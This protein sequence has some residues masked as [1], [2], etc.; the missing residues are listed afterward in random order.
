[1]MVLNIKDRTVL[2]VDGDLIINKPF[3]CPDKHW[4]LNQETKEFE[5]VLH[6]RYA[7]YQ[8]REPRT[9]AFI[10]ESLQLVNDI[11][12]ALIRWRSRGRPGLS[13]ITRRLLDH[14][15]NPKREHQ[16]F[17][18]QLEAVET[19]IFLTEDATGRSIAQRIEGDGGPLERWC[20]KMA[21]GTGKTVLM[22]MLIAWQ[23]LNYAGASERQRRERGWVRNFLILAPNLTVRDRLQVLLPS[24]NGNYYDQFALVPPGGGLRQKLNRAKLL[25]TNWHKLAP[26]TESGR[27]V[28]KLD[29]ETDVAFTA[30]VFDRTLDLTEPFLVFNDEAHHAWR[31]PPDAKPTEYKK[32]DRETATV[33]IQGLDRLHKMGTLVR[34]YDFTATPFPPSGKKTQRGERLFPWVVSDFGLSDAIESGLVKTP[35]IAAEDNLTSP[36]D[37]PLPGLEE[38]GLER[39]SKLF[40]LYEEEG[41]KE[42]LRG[43]KNMIGEHLP[44]LVVSAYQLLAKS[45]SDTLKEWRRQSSSVPPVMV[46]ICNRTETAERV[47][48]LF[49][50]LKQVHDEMSETETTLHYDSTTIKAVEKI[51]AGERVVGKAGEQAERLREIA[52][53]VGVEG[54]P[55]GQIRH[56][57]AVNMISEGWDAKTVTHIMGLRAFTSQLLCEQVIGRGLRRT[58]Y[59]LNEDGSFEP[60][61]VRIFG[62]PFTLL[63]A[64]KETTSRAIISHPPVD[65]H[66]VEKNRKF[67]VA[68]PAL[69]RVE[70]APRRTLKID[71]DDVDPLMLRADEVFTEAGMAKTLEYVTA[72]PDETVLRDKLEAIRLQTLA[73]DAARVFYRSQEGWPDGGA[74]MWGQL[75]LVMLDFVKNP[76]KLQIVGNGVSERVVIKAGLGQIVRHLRPYL[77]Q[78]EY[79]IMEGVYENPH[80]PLLSTGEMRP[81]VTRRHPEKIDAFVGRTHL[82]VGVYD[83]ILEKQAGRIF[84]EHRNVA[85]WVKNDREHIGFKVDYVFEG[86]S[87]RYYPDFVVRL[88]PTG[89]ESGRREDENNLIVETKGA[90]EAEACAKQQYLNLWLKA[91]NK[92]GRWGKWENFGLVFEQDFPRLIARLDAGA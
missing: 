79:Q 39:R 53:T 30:R 37:D 81:W 43:G 23:T 82:N 31:V 52:K 29:P 49:I 14:W 35:R 9:G 85:G 15:E 83:S 61:Y 5:L 51:E 7:S 56:V 12:E 8:L 70:T 11:R 4:K 59:E 62:V 65:V 42:N 67:E 33:W 48:R 44:T 66:T 55:G 57:I 60:E 72:E 21:T 22:A 40:H 41:V 86:R 71:W 50:D 89:E 19:I 3:A 6:R 32:E 38:D 17:Y 75:A 92:D 69:L 2:G 84:S 28:V 24:H 63:L 88:R 64:E 27:G 26:Q 76:E 46:S 78:E 47:K 36:D 13:S 45:W 77:F 54:S 90:T 58:S 18:A 25:I 80:R 68:W 73:F 34:C 10:E 16:L 20:A 74:A 87:V 91:V 1:M